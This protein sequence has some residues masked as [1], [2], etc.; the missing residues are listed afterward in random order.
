M[1][2]MNGFEF[3]SN[4]ES[5]DFKVIFVTAFEEF[6]LQAF[7]FYALDYLVKPVNPIKL[8]RAVEKLGQI[9]YEFQ[10]M[11]EMLRAI[12]QIYQKS[13]LLS[14]PT[15]NG[16]EMIDLDDIKYLMAEGNYVELFLKQ[17]KLVVSKSLGDFEKVL[18]AKKFIRIHNSY[19]VKVSE[20]KKYI[21]GDGGIVELIGGI[22]LPV[23][24]LN[25]PKLLQLI[26]VDF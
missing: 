18:D 10:K 9:S 25:K 7:D 6:A 11:E 5:P 16:L 14:I 24:R 19:I 3:L 8:Q 23:S 21:R 4:F 26:K 22:Q 15:L 17:D 2:E 13:N 12:Q 20:I 1:P